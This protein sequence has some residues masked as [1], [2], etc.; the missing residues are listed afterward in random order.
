[1][2]ICLDGYMGHSYLSSVFFLSLCLVFSVSFSQL[3]CPL[4]LECSLR[5]IVSQVTSYPHDVRRRSDSSQI[6][7]TPLN[8]VVV[9]ILD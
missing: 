2:P 5:E 4:A 3:A 9:R 8:S 6:S 7:G 1:M